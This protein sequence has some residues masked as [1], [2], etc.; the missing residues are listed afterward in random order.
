M[1]NK[2]GAIVIGGGHAGIEAVVA[3]KKLG[4]NPLLITQKK[5]TIGL[6]PCNTSIGGSAK[7]VLVKEIDSLGGI[8]G[9]ASDATMLQIKTLNLSKGPATWSYRSQIDKLT[10][11]RFMQNYI[12]D[13]K[14]DILEVMV[15]EILTKD[16][17]FSGI[18]TSDGKIYNAKYCVMTTGTYTNSIVIKAF[19]KKEEGPDG[20]ETNKTLSDSLVKMGFDLKRLKTGTPP[21]IKESTIDFSSFEVE[22]G[23]NDKISFSFSNEQKDL[24]RN[25]IDCYIAYTNEKTHEVVRNNLDK[26][27]LFVEEPLGPSPRFCPSIEDKVRKFTD[28]SRHQIFLEKESMENDSV[29]M[30]G[31]S[32]SLPDEIQLEFLRTIKGLEK[33]EVLKYGYAIEY[34]SI[35]PRQ[36]KLTLET[37]LIENL[38]SAGQINGT[39]GYEEAAAQGLMAAINISKKE[40]EEEVFILK[41]SEAYIGV[42]IDDIVTKGVEDP[43]RMLTSRSEYRLIL[44]NDNVEKRLLRKGKEVGLISQ[45]V[46]SKYEE[47]ENKLLEA[48]ETL[49]KTR[50]LP[51]NK[52]IE[53][54]LLKI[55]TNKLVGGVSLLELMKRPK[56][57]F[58]ELK[59]IVPELKDINLSFRQ[60]QSLETEIKFEGYIKQ[61]QRL[62]EKN[63]NYD[64]FKIPENFDFGSVVN[65]ASEA[66]EKL[67][68]IQ[69]TTIAQAERISG[70]NPADIVQ[71][72]YFFRKKNK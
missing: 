63:K 38:Y 16:N 55:E 45:E 34:D 26:S 67:N 65:L 17:K 39:S 31:I 50:V 53:K 2:Y 51:K 62:I 48:T 29:Y 56:V 64:D 7:G 40:K 22:P 59:K 61:Q 21:R 35:D 3:L 12:D 15:D 69:P 14:I 33:V 46:W 68:K 4:F 9:I 32:S 8:M 11:P 1:K 41:R 43:Y 28:K 13:L 37:K 24:N 36:L 27:C 30:Q 18:K 20:L 57:R 25:Q 60:I 54:Y 42:L 6:M 19:T 58:E 23:T 71:L 47:Y 72:I 10:Y 44:R 70:V 49:S 52:E 5:S 66:T